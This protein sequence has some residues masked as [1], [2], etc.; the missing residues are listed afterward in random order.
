MAEPVV[1]ERRQ[2]NVFGVMLSV[3]LLAVASVG[4]TGDPWWL[5]NAATK[6]IVA[7]L[8][9]VIGVVLL[10]TALPGRRRATRQ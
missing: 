8:I 7:G 6:W 5:F 4:F 1:R 3:V 2:A 10:L 9:A